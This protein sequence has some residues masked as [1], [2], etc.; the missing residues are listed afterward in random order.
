MWSRM[1]ERREEA[2]EVGGRVFKAGWCSCA[3]LSVRS[4]RS[5][6][7]VVSLKLAMNFQMDIEVNLC[8][9]LDIL[10]PASSS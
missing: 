8:D 5:S 2:G 10:D 3:G 9:N 1:V 6:L 7:E 4:M